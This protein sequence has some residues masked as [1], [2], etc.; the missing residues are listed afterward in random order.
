[1][2][3]TPA[4]DI[5]LRTRAARL[6]SLFANLRGAV[7]ANLLL[8]LLSLLVSLNDSNSGTVLI[9]FALVMLF[10]GWRLWLWKRWRSS[11]QPS[12]PMWERRYTA[13]AFFS[14][15]CWGAF[16][17]FL[18]PVDAPIA[19]GVSIA[20]LL[21]LALGAAAMLASSRSSYLLFTL[22]IFCG[23]LIRVVDHP[24]EQA[25]PMALGA[26][27]FATLA[28]IS[29]S[30][31][32]ES[33][34]EA[35]RKRFEAE[36]LLDEQ[37]T[38]LDTAGDGIALIVGGRVTKCNAALSRLLGHPEPSLI[39]MSARAWYTDPTSWRR[40][41]VESAPV[42]RRGGTFSTR[43]TLRHCDGRLLH[44]ECRGRAIDPRSVR[45]GTVWTLRDISD[46]L[47]AEN[48]LRQSE[49]RFR[50]LLEL[51][52]DWYWEQDSDLRF[53]R[54]EE[55][56]T[57]VHVLPA[58]RVEG[59]RRW[60]L[61]LVD[62]PDSPQ[63][64]A[65]IDCCHAHRPYREFIYAVLDQN[66]NKRWMSANGDPIFAP[67][68]TFLGYHGTAIDITQRM[69]AEQQ[70]HHLA[71]HDSLTDLPNRR[72]LHDRFERSLELAKRKKRRMGVLA[73]DLDGFKAVNDHY[74]HAM[75]DR[76]LLEVAKRLKEAVREIDTAARSGGDEFTVL[77]AE[78]TQSRDIDH[79]CHKIKAQF[80]VPIVVD[81]HVFALGG[82]IGAACFPD[83]GDSPETL[84]HAADLA[85]YAAKKAGGHC[86]VV[87]AP[88]DNSTCPLDLR[89]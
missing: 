47:A 63:W 72:L 77:L 75:G 69:Q 73:I 84:L 54:V 12:H 24:I 44:C 71:H 43:V 52:S 33:L 1:M 80:A 67:D 10:Q 45:R 37:R 41:V 7:L 79:V 61:P 3:T 39:G 29:F 85:M 36:A 31:A 40:Q 50:S 4:S 13:G 2:A 59:K 62:N 87:A 89:A 57:G 15:L 16:A 38:L 74:G 18:M 65:H 21:G 17:L 48:R 35:L 23:L 82:S 70:V 30:R 6:A 25:V 14:G 51:S 9:W 58:Q 34:S 86:H 81:D 60:E 68:G 42:L 46:Q 49:G 28:W 27:L 20:M 56:R 53:I 5:G 64:L 32:Y 76:V 78:L 88:K 26:V 22:P 8:A 55:Y 19:M 11:S 66:G 83:H